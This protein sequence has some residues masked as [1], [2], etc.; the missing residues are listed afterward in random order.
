VF[1]G[2]LPLRVVL[3]PLLLF[4]S[5]PRNPPPFLPL[6]FASAKPRVLRV[7]DSIPLEHLASFLPLLFLPFPFWEELSVRSWTSRWPWVLFSFL[8]PFVAR[9]TRPVPLFPPWFLPLSSPGFFLASQGGQVRLLCLSRRSREYL[10]L[11]MESLLS[12]AIFP[13]PH[14][15]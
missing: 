8:P 5:T 10:L 3:P 12:A 6:M 2:P 14:L 11:R 1:A 13:T 4:S 15:L 7:S 9:D